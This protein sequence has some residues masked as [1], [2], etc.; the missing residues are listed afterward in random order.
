MQV[1]YGKIGR[2]R[3]NHFTGEQQ[4]PIYKTYYIF[5]TYNQLGKNDCTTSRKIKARNLHIQELATMAFKDAD[6]L[7]RQLSSRM[8]RRYM[9]DASE[10]QEECEHLEVRIRQIEN[11]FLSLYA[12]KIKCM[13]SE[14]R[15]VK[16]T[17]AI[18]QE[19]EENQYRLKKV[20]RIFQ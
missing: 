5:Q 11:M 19:Q 7:Y 20:M 14:Q 18:E 8:K 10:I 17:A 3:K 2:T 15:F 9:F 12:D 13:I 1:R 6:A 16:L 4:E